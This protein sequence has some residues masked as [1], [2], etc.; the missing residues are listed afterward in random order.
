MIK[1]AF[2][3]VILTQCGERQEVLRQGSPLGDYCKGPG[4]RRW[5][6]VGRG[7]HP[8]S[9]T[10]SKQV[11]GSVL[12]AGDHGVSAGPDTGGLRAAGAGTR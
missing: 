9:N 11:R 12:S 4:R 6:E 10:H 8:L 7:P 3:K 2:L 1:L 5:P